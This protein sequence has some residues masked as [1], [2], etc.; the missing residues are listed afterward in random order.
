MPKFIASY[1]LTSMTP[2]PHSEFIT[3]SRKLGWLPWILSRNDLW[4][5]LPN[6]TLVGTFATREAAVAALKQ[7][8]EN[9]SAEIG[10]KIVMEKWIVAE[11]S[12]ASFDSDETQKKS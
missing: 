6:T 9:A 5:R 2:S 12:G 1:D 7:A 10:K 11:Y 8:R 4:Y 3:Q